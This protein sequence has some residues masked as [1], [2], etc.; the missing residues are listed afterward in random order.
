ME[1]TKFINHDVVIDLSMTTKKVSQY[2]SLLFEFM[3][4]GK[5]LVE[6]KSNHKELSIVAFNYDRQVMFDLVF[7][8]HI[9]Y[10]NEEFSSQKCDYKIYFVKDA[11]DRRMLH[12]MVFSTIKPEDVY[13]NFFQFD[14]STKTYNDFNYRQLIMMIVNNNKFRRHDREILIAAT[15]YELDFE[16]G[17]WNINDDFDF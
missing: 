4:L 10:N 15:E 14:D 8:L 3:H 2:Y 6:N 12:Y 16:N 7:D 1:N 5:S 13:F 17:L 11:D 9:S